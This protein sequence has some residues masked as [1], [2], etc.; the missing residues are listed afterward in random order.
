MLNIN[1][2]NEM[3]GETNKKKDLGLKTFNDFHANYIDKN[4]VDIIE[5]SG[6]INTYGYEILC[7]LLS[8]KKQS[9]IALLIIGT[10]GGDPNA[11]FRMA[12]AL[13]HEYTFFQALIPRYCKSAGTL[14]IIGATALYMDDKSEL[15][16]LD[17]QIL[18]HDELF[19][20]RSGLEIG[21]AVE[22]IRNQTFLT[23]RMF[24][25]TLTTEYKLSTKIAA[26]M[27]YNLSRI[28]Y[29]PL[30]EQIDPLKLAENQRA[31]DI[32]F[33]YADRL[34]EKSKNLCDN[35][36]SAL[37]ADYPTHGFVIDRKE[38]RKAFRNVLRPSGKL[39]DLGREFHNHSEE[40]IDDIRAHI[41]IKTIKLKEL[42][43]IKDEQ[44]I[45]LQKQ[46]IAHNP[47][48]K[49]QLSEAIDNFK[50]NQN[51][52]DIPDPREASSG[53]GKD[54]EQVARQS[55]PKRESKRRNAQPTRKTTEK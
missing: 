16:P 28:I 29:Q 37:V 32:G 47:N 18:R 46:L 3:N 9:D 6:Q 19:T 15:G 54:I 5:Y 30:A 48:C 22:Y 26:D 20:R 41:E 50:E 21:A 2:E 33:A 17:I 51:D 40:S 53:A 45:L 11:A 4:Y 38:A 1:L 39:L 10:P 55:H 42:F 31:N 36:L 23:F 25:K 8:K 14:L 12:R 52:I 7:D 34:N 43:N 24:L 44:T 35:G 49:N 27:S 13:Q